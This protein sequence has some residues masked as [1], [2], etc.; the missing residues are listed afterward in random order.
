[1]WRS[2]LLSLIISSLGGKCSIIVER[3]K[4]VE[5]E[6]DETVGAVGTPF[7]SSLQVK[8]V[9]LPMKTFKTLRIEVEIEMLFFCI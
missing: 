5:A 2:C 3:L 7:N 9:D 8:Y 6:E 4:P 1:M